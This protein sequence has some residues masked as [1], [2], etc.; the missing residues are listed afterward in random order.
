MLDVE[1]DVAYQEKVLGELAEA[2]AQ[3]SVDGDLD[4]ARALGVEYTQVEADLERLLAEWAAIE[5]ADG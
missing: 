5:E 4:R 1:E 3:A 2:M